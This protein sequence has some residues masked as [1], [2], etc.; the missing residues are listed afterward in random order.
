MRYLILLIFFF[1]PVIYSSAQQKVN[2]LH[3][4]FNIKLNDQNDTIYGIAEIELKIP[5]KIRGFDIGLNL[6]N[7]T[8][9]KGMI[10]DSIRFPGG[11]VITPR[12]TQFMKPSPFF[13]EQEKIEFVFGAAF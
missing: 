9:G 7:E 12:M 8:T 4:K 2:V 13:T 10:V 1:S 5:E 6:Q 11:S 3:Y